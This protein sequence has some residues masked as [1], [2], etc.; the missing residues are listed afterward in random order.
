MSLFQ[1]TTIDGVKRQLSDSSFM[2]WLSWYCC[3]CENKNKKKSHQQQLVLDIG[4]KRVRKYTKSS[5][6]PKNEKTT[7]IRQNLKKFFTIQFLIKEFF[8]H[9][10]SVS[11]QSILASITIYKTSQTIIK[12]LN[13]IVH[14]ILCGFCAPLWL[15]KTFTSTNYLFIIKNDHEK[16]KNQCHFVSHNGFIGGSQWV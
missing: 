4:R 8:F 1:Q 3:C 15:N 10:E 13:K 7:T 11:L 9:F 5:K 16:D 6:N 2:L 14:Y 12:T